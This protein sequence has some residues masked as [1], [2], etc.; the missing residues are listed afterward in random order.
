[1]AGPGRPR[2]LAYL[3][4]QTEATRRPWLAA[5]LDPIGAADFAAYAHLLHAAG[6]PA[7][8]DRARTLALHGAIPHLLAGAPDTLAAAGL[9]DLEDFAH[10]VLACVCPEPSEEEP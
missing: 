5:L 9:D 6:L 10:G 7:G 3:E 1:M 2:V 4:L 8:P